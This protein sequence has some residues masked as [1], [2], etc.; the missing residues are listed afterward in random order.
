MAKVTNTYKKLILLIA[1]FLIGFASLF[2]LNRIFLNLEAKLDKQTQNL[3]ARITIGEFIAYDIVEIRSLF[4]ELATTTSTQKARDRVIEKIEDTVD[5]IKDSLDVLE[6]GGTLKR[7]V[8]LNIVGHLNTIKT[9][10]YTATSQEYILEVIDIKPKLDEIL[11]KVN[12]I[13]HLLYIR[14]KFKK[15]RD[16]KKFMRA[17]KK[18]RRYYKSLPAYF[19]RMTE[20]TRRLL[21]EGELEL[22]QLETKIKH[23]K[24]KYM[25][26]KLYL[27]LFV[28]FIVIVFGYMIVK[29]VNKES[30]E[31]YELNI[32]LNNTLAK[33]AKQERAIRGILDAQ[34]NIIIVSN[35]EEMLDA[36]LQLIKFFDQ[37]KDFEDFKKKTKCICDFFE[38]DVPNEEY[39]T[40]KGY[41]NLKWMELLLK[42]PDKH[43]KVIIKNHGEKYHFLIQAVETILDD[44]TGESVIIITFNDI[45]TEINSQIKL[46]NLNE[47]LE[48]LVADKTKELQELNEN[49]EQKVII[50]SAKARKK[51]KQLM[52]QSRFAALGE[53]IGNI[54]HQWR[55]PLSAIGSISSGVKLQM[56][57]GLTTEEEI[58]QS[59]DKIIDNIEFLSQTIEDFRGFFKEDKELVDFDII[60]TINKTLS[61]LETTY[62]DNNIKIIT[63]F[64]SDKFISNGMPSELSQVILN[65]L[66]N[67]KDATV[68]NNIENRLVHIEVKSENGKNIIQ[69]QDNAGGIPD[70]IIDKIFDPYF[71]TKHQSQGTG[72]GLYMSKDIIEN[73]M[74]GLISV[75]NLYIK[76]DDIYYNGACF[77]IVL[78]EVKKDEV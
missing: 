65:I 59:F 3:E 75:Q 43:F 62:K 54:A 4:H 19:T 20:N 29:R 7:F 41:G 51:D 68:S 21:Y 76:K 47:N 32:N 52:Q 61:I 9:V 14:S 30:Q 77:K 45:T 13:N 26:I 8:A 72:I 16:T 28:V 44:E 49:L 36:N 23:D 60:Q 24:E 34:S 74:K 55:Q 33:Q 46:A 70:D 12:E 64:K 40:K 31:L 38:D 11:K 63:D 71:T 22:K 1:I 15:A 57:L 66:N 27:I 18:I 37:F 48:Q 67:A 35:G 25:R 58:K 73:H 50:E 42:N 56:E 10:H 53:M 2:A 39:I 69:I 6:H 5:I 78:D 17:A